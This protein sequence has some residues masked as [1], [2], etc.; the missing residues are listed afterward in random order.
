MARTT[1]KRNGDGSAVHTMK[2]DG[3]PPT[4]FIAMLNTFASGLSPKRTI[5][6]DDDIQRHPGSAL[7]LPQDMALEQGVEILEAKIEEQNSSTRFGRVFNYRPEDGANATANVLTRMFGLVVG[8]T[9]AGGMFSPPQPPQNLSIDVAYGRKREAP[10]GLISVPKLGDAEVELDAARGPL[11]P[12]FAVNVTALKKYKAEV[13]AFF[14]A[15]DEELRVASIY[16]GQALEGA[17]SLSFL[18][19]SGFDASKI[20]FSDDVTATLDAALWS[21]L[22]HS[23]ATEAVGM[24]LRRAVLLY[25][26]FGTGKSSIGLITAQQAV[27]HGWTFLSAKAGRDNLRDVMLAAKLYQRAVVFIEDIDAHAPASSDKDAMSEL[28]D[29]FDGI[30]VKDTQILLVATTNHIE[31]VPAGLLR[32]GR[33]DYV[34]PI[35]GLDRNGTERLLRAVVPDDLLGPIDFDEVYEHTQQWQ[36]AWIKAVGDRAQSFALTRTGGQVNYLL[37]TEDLVGAAKSL[38]AQLALMEKATEG[39]HAPTLDT[40]LRDLIGAGTREVLDGAELLDYDG[41]YDGKIRVRR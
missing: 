14:D 9:K 22:Q 11:G 23:A 5:I 8:K 15:I 1:E 26:P 27:A 24:K 34:I 40:A 41:A 6:T 29:M 38:Q 36:P 25:G 3:P 10:W 7:I 20:V 28:L 21:V 19:L 32:P 18:D 30:A 2:I 39:T 4:E 31:T 16:R 17:H 13:T 33:M 35:E 37:T 12:V